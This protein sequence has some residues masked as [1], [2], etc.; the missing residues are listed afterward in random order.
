[1]AKYYRI[2]DEMTASDCNRGHIS[3]LWCGEDD[4]ARGGVS[5]CASMEE[6]A[7]YFAGSRLGGNSPGRGALLDGAYLTIMTG[8]VSDD[9]PWEAE[10]ECLVHPTGIIQSELIKDEFMDELA[11]LIAE[12]WE[13]K[14]ARYAGGGDWEF[15]TECDTCE[16]GVVEYLDG[17]TETCNECEGGLRWEMAE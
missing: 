7:E 9:T 12:M 17:T 6:L 5:C 14:S 8:D 3:R 1:M 2:G 11:Q 16:R 10:G 15:L 4:Q 13:E